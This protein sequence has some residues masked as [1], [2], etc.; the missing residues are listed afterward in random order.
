MVPEVL[1]GFPFFAGLSEAELKSISS[2]ADE[3]SFQRGDFVFRE[4]SQAGALFLLLDGWVDIVINTD[5]GGDRYELMMTLTPGDVFGCSA[6]VEPY[7]YTASA[8]CVSPVRALRFKGA[9]LL[10]LFEIDFHLRCIMMKN[11]CRVVANRLR[12]TRLQLL[13]LV[14]AHGEFYLGHQ[15]S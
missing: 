12:S 6:V 1:K 8:M 4:D 14:A 13:S 11:I 9:D 2:V 7:L 5:A 10:A 15:A 3:V